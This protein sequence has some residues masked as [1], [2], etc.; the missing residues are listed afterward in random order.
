MG[1]RVSG[2]GIPR[3][4]LDMK[5]WKKGNLRSLLQAACLGL[6]AIVLLPSCV[7]DEVRLGTED[8]KLVDS[9][10][11]QQRNI[12]AEQL[13]DTCQVY[14]EMH[15]ETWIDSIREVRLREI[16]MLIQ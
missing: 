8:L 14:R 11:I 9:L 13:K 5:L 15:L 10:F 7:Q 1:R 4:S 12:W 2:V 16:E 6:A 3:M